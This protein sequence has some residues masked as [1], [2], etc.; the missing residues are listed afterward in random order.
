MIDYTLVWV[1]DRIVQIY[2]LNDEADTTLYV[3]EYNLKIKRIVRDLYNAGKLR[4]GK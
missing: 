2:E 4:R 3:P 1:L